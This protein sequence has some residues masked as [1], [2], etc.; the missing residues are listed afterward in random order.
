MIIKK[1][2]LQ[3]VGLGLS[4]SL[5]HA[6]KFNI[7]AGLGA[8]NYK[9]DLAPK[10]NPAFFRPAG[11]LVFRYNLSPSISL[12]TGL[13]KGSITADDSKSSDPYNQ[14]RNQSFKTGI[15]EFNFIAEYNFL[16]YKSKP[17]YINW[18]P[19]V[20]GGLAY[21]NFKPQFQTGSYSTKQIAIPF[22]IGLKWEI[23]RPWSLEFEFGTRKLFTDNIDNLGTNI[24]TT[25]KYK[26]GNAALN[27]VY[28][29]SSVT[30]S[31]TFYKIV[32]P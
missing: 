22:G 5:S 6:Q 3:L 11:S 31:Y 23:K 32:C 15:T 9:G 20:F 7:G 2:I 19:Y 8:M 14:I 24:T 1:I 26:Q 12:R 18:T 28:Y 25:Q 30:L 21:Y 4:L 29:Y 10:F 16:N 17:R 13:L 27:D